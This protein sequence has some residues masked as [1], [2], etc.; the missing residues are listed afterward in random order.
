MYN[1]YPSQ[2]NRWHGL[3]CDFFWLKKVLITSENNRINDPRKSFKK[4][5]KNALTS[6]TK[7]SD[8]SIRKLRRLNST[9]ET[10]EFSD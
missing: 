1:K 3:W 8:V 4:L 5:L 10:S 7:N 2:T 6:Q 9:I